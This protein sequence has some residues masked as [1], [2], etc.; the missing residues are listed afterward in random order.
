MRNLLLVLILVFPLILYAQLPEFYK[1]YDEV[2]DSLFELETLH[3]DIIDVFEIGTTIYDSLP[4]YAVKISNNVQQN[5]DVPR[6]LVVGVIHGEEIMMVE[7]VLRVVSEFANNNYSPWT[8]YKA[9][10]ELFFIPVMNVEGYNVVLDEIDV[11][12]RKNKRDNVGDGLFRY[13]SGWGGDS[14]GVDPNR[15]FDF[16]WVHGDT[17]FQ[18]GSEERYDYYRGPSPLSEPINQA[19]RNLA[20]EEDFVLGIIYH[21]S[22]TGNLSERVI[23]P[24]NWKD[25]G[26]Q[27]GKTAP[28]FNVI[29]DIGV[30]L[31]SK[32]DRLGVSGTYEP[33]ASASKNGNAQ[34]WFYAKWGCFQY[35]IETSSIQL[36]LYSDLMQCVENNKEGFYYLLERAIGYGFGSATNPVGQLTGII[37]DS[38]TGDP[39]EAEVRIL[40]RDGKILAPRKSDSI[41]GRYR[42]LLMAGTYTVE[43]K[44]PGY[45]DKV[46]TV[47]IGQVAPFTFN[48]ALDPLPTYTVSGVIK[49]TQTNQNVDGLIYFEGNTTETLSVSPSGFD[50][51]LPQSHYSIRIESDNYVPRFEEIDLN[52]SGYYEF[53]LSPATEI[54]SDDFESGLGSWT[55][56]GDY[57]W[58]IDYSDSHSGTA[59]VSDSPGPGEFYQNNTLG[60]IET[61]IDLTSYQTAALSWWN[62]Y[63]L[64]PEYDFGYVEASIDGGAEWDLLHVYEL[65]DVDWYQEFADLTDFCGSEVI[66]RFSL[67]TDDNLVEPGWNLDDVQVVASDTFNNIDSKNF[68]PHE[69]YL[70]NP[71]PNPFNSSTLIRFSLDLPGQAVLTVF[72]VQ[73]R[74]L[75]VLFSGNVSEGEKEINWDADSY[76][77]GLYFLKLQSNERTA[78]TK[79]LL[80]K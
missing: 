58:A 23:Y 12:Y 65:Q 79:V 69:F 45:E 68:S 63:Y 15:N 36:P 31:A 35:T 53:V 80:I 41:Y 30:R 56:G 25:S 38:E 61:T 9:Q 50:I 52:N 66:I 54:F 22:R 2:M 11:S 8:I 60:Y 13:M 48:I 14:S 18:E 32:I 40:E 72:D 76:A 34:D 78:T 77:S 64:E 47:S 46:Q 16:N 67:E 49:D 19:V 17:L 39:L 59:S 7:L 29:N 27:T 44:A 26:V 43:V 51:D 55:L 62:K 1:T 71:F 57:N 70:G 75:E 24:W 42:R 74:Q 10:S 73:G 37:T 3:P 4:I 6:V 33:N 21:Q 28:D 20:E 5:R